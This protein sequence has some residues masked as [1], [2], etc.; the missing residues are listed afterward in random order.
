MIELH[1][2]LER[3]TASVSHHTPRLPQYHLYKE[4]GICH[5]QIHVWRQDPGDGIDGMFV[6][7][8][9]SPQWHDAFDA[10]LAQLELRMENMIL[11]GGRGT[12]KRTPANSPKLS[13]GD[14]NIKV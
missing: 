10:A 1:N 12:V 2:W 14:L 9:F 3:I 6:G 7:K 8:G 11:E 5:V 13:L 4:N